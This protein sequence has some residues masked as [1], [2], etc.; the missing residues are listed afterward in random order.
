MINKIFKRIKIKLKKHKWFINYTKDPCREF[1]ESF[2]LFDKEG[3]GLIRC[4]ELGSVMR[5]LGQ[6]PTSSQLQDM[7]NELDADGNGTIDL[8]EF[9]TMMSRKMKDTDSE[10]EI[11]EAFRVFD[12]AGDGFISVA[13]LRHVMTNL[14]EKLTDQE[15]DEMIKEAHVD[16]YGQINY[17]KFINSLLVIVFLFNSK[18]SFDVVL[19]TYSL[20]KWIWSLMSLKLY[21][22]LNR[23]VLPTQNW[24]S[25]ILTIASKLKISVRSRS[26]T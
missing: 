18:I 22:E 14:G 12:T 9:L 4:K 3:D 19:D 23:V 11:C 16:A 5:S 2:R 1:I 13:D 7:L 25:F 24:T 17:E 8:P 15:I 26:K 20:V 6:N 21:V 10:E